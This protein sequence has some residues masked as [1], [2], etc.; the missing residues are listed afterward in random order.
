MNHDNR[1]VRWGVASALNQL[2]EEGREA[3]DNALASSDA[4]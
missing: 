4:Q 3:V 2:G 1:E